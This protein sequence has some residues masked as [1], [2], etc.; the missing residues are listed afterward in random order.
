MDH[1]NKR[2]NRYTLREKWIFIF[3]RLI[4]LKISSK[5]SN[6]EKTWK[7]KKKKIEIENIFQKVP[8]HKINYPLHIA[9]SLPLG[10]RFPK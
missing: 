9:S 4:Y 5:I 8:K 7:F 2:Q 3:F 10:I 6:Q 1:T